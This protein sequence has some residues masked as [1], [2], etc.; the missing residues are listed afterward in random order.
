[1]DPD[2]A[3]RIAFEEVSRPRPLHECLSQRELQILRLLSQGFSVSE[4][5]E[6]LYISHKTVSTHKARLMEKM[7][8]KNNAELIRYGL[9]H[10]LSE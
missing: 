3:Q 10:L 7:Q 5:A 4:I 9:K 1:M 2:L 6:Q 8:F